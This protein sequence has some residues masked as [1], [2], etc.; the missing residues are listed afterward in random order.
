MKWWG[1]EIE[2]EFLEDRTGKSQEFFD[3]VLQLTDYM[4]NALARQSKEERVDL[5][6][7]QQQW[8][9][10]VK[11]NQNLSDEEKEKLTKYVTNMTEN[12]KGGTTMKTEKNEE[13][14]SIDEIV[15]VV[16][17]KPKLLMKH[18]FSPHDLRDVSWTDVNEMTKKHQFRADEIVKAQKVSVSFNGVT[19]KFHEPDIVYDTP[20]VYV[21]RKPGGFEVV[22]RKVGGTRDIYPSEGQALRA[23]SAVHKEERL[24]EKEE[25]LTTYEEMSKVE[26][27][28][29]KEED[30]ILGR[31]LRE[32]IKEA[33][34]KL[35]ATFPSV[36]R[37][38]RVDSGASIGEAGIDRKQNPIKLAEEDD[39]CDIEFADPSGRSALR[40][41][42]RTN[43]RNLPCPTCRKPNRITPADRAR[44]YQCDE[45]ANRAEGYGD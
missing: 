39:Y 34:E 45:C 7:E 9:S 16:T 12:L 4:E 30:S 32:K 25:A 22:E 11:E 19:E 41:S 5:D 2:K 40:A 35:K 15:E 36:G 3:I 27:R 20:E 43:P 24:R 1:E 31:E 38:T 23:A 33:K 42:S 28:L 10:F 44:G 13:I 21:E 8:L 37:G 26:E 29:A 14:P 17:T 18:Q 6:S